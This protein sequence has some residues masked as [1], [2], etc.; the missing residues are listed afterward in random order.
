[1]KDLVFLYDDY[2]HEIIG[3]VAITGDSTK[4]TIQDIIDKI[5]AKYEGEWSYDDIIE[6]LPSDCLYYPLTN[7]Y[8]LI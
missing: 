3:A 7:N 5:K 8:A 4:E 1:M 6:E 2:D